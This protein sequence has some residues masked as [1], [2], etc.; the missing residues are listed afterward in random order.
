MPLANLKSITDIGLLVADID[1]AVAFYHDTLGFAIKRRDLGFAELWTEG[2]IL[3]LWETA[4]LVKAVPF[5]EKARRGPHAML[6]VRVERAELVDE[7]YRQLKAK[8]VDCRS[9]PVNH[10][11]NARAFYFADPDDNWW[12][13]YHWVAPART[14]NDV[15]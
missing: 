3:C 5:A 1:R 15:E 8:G 7:I 9:E 13:V 2:V 11:W 10:P 4:D 12:E 6:A 14:L